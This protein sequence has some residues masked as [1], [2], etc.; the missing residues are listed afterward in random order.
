MPPIKAL[1][2]FFLFSICA[3]SLRAQSIKGSWYGVGHIQMDGNSE[4]YLSE[5]LLLQDGTNIKAEFN[6]YFRD[7]LFKNKIV[8]TYD[9]KTRLLIIKK[10]PIIYYRSTSTKKAVMVDMMGTFEFRVAKTG[11]VLNG[12]LTSYSEHSFLMP[13]INYRL[14]RDTLPAPPKKAT[15]TKKENNIPNV[16]KK[17]TTPANPKIVAPY[18]AIASTANN[19]DTVIKK[20]DTLK[21]TKETKTDIPVIIPATVLTEEAFHARKKDYA[22][23]IDI[24]NSSIKL[25][26]YDNG[27]IDYDSVSLLLNDKVILP[28]AMLT[29]RS[30]KLTINLDESLEYNELGM[31]AEN[32]GMIPPNTAALIIRDGNKKYELT[33][34]SDFSKNAIIQLRTKKANKKD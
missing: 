14:I 31:F 4:N 23:I 24:E 10:F 33:L 7:S 29:H 30:I 32:L 6:Y 19:K 34:N 22:K 1:F 3:V 12:S 18:I 8:C 28:K 16:E 25:E 5:L 2:V 9:K 13:V 26:V 20:M 27:S 21:I 11:S 15:I 17:K